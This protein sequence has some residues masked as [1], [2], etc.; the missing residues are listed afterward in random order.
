MSDTRPMRVREAVMLAPT[1]RQFVL[2]PSDGER[3][4]VAAAGA[5]VVVHLDHG[6]RTLRRAY[7]LC[8]DPG[9]RGSFRIIVRRVADSRGGSAWL[10][11]AARPGDILRV[12]PP[13]N[14]FPIP[15]LARRHVLLAAGVGVTPFLAYLPHLAAAGIPARLHQI[16]RPD[17]AHV[18]RALLA[19]HAASAT[20]HPGRADLAP[21]LADQPLGTHV[22]VCGPE[23]FMAEA[24][25][26]ARALGYP[27]SKIHRESFAGAAPGAA[28]VAVLARAGRRVA[29]DA[30]TSLLEALERAGLE[31]P[32]LCRGGVCGQCRVPVLAGTPEHRDHV[33]SAAERAGGGAIMTCV[34]RAATP[35]LVLDL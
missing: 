13:E 7:S 18:F 12:G 31:P 33:L 9:A 2:E 23:A 25:R 10:H 24:E 17:E 30:D 5:H 28:F 20:I 21:L 11:A 6:G 29:V 22:S 26:A 27:P 15:G 8:G 1:L 16:C 32:S 4:P 19:D 14:L 34:S 35:E 3:C